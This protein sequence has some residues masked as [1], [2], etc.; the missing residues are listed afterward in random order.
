MLTVTA[1][2]SNG[3]PVYFNGAGGANNWPLK[4]GKMGNWDGGIRVNAWVRLPRGSPV[5][6][7]SLSQGARHQVSGG[8]LP[9][10]VRGEAVF[11]IDAR[12]P[13]M[14]TAVLV[15]SPV[16]LA[17]RTVLDTK[18]ARLSPGVIDVIELSHGVAVVAEGYW[19][20]H[21]GAKL[22]QVEPRRLSFTGVWLSFRDHLLLKEPATLSDWQD[23]YAAALISAGNRKLPTRSKPRSYARRAHPRRPK[24]TKFMKTQRQARQA[25]NPSEND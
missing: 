20:A 14:L 12:Q 7:L 2:R 16:V 4:G 21:K 23:L 18:A 3:G 17:R 24:S 13:G 1:P 11:G 8:F 6:P 5:V 9:P 19:P 25:N 10:K 15:R 22:V